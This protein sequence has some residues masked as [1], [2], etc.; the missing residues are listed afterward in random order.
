MIK[1]R[2]T[3]IKEKLSAA[4][5]K[6]MLAKLK[7]NK[8]APRES[9]VEEDKDALKERYDALVLKIQSKEVVE[10]EEDY[11]AMAVL[12]YLKTVKEDNF[13]SKDLQAHILFNVVM[14]FI[15]QNTML[16]CMLWSLISNVLGEYSQHFTNDFIVLLVKFPCTVALHLF[17]F[18]EVQT[19]MKIMKFANNQPH[20]FTGTGAEISFFIGFMQVIT[21]IYCEAIN[22][23][24]LT[25]QHTVEHC[26][27]HFVALEVIMEI[28]KLYFEALTDYQLKDILHY[29]PKNE[30]KGKDIPL[31]SRSWFHILARITYKVLR[32]LY[33]S[34]IFYFVPYLSIYLN[35]TLGETGGEHGGGHGGGH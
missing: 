33:V 5:Q 15:F 13:I 8:A 32:G 26:I 19:G 28:P 17:L 18:P 23:Y 29:H 34:V 11:N 1:K 14:V 20:L 21:S 16:T 3:E 27:I 9:L 10:F 22:L 2:Q 6:M 4:T 25:F 31:L 24:L 7:N 35:Y 30:V 12:S